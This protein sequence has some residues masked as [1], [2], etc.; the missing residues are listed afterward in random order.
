MEKSNIKEQ[1]LQSMIDELSIN[2]KEDGLGEKYSELLHNIKEKEHEMKKANKGFL[3]M[4]IL[5]FG[6][7][8]ASI[9]GNF[10]LL[11]RN[12]QV[13]LE[14]DNL[15]WRDS[16]FNAIMEPD[17]DKSVT[18]RI[19][20]GKI[21]TYHQLE[22][23]NDSFLKKYHEEKNKNQITQDSYV[24]R[25]KYEETIFQN[26]ILKGRINFI[27]SVY[28]IKIVEEKDGYR[29]VSPEIDSALL[30]LPHYRNML[31]RNSKDHSWTIKIVN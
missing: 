21:V 22:Q 27:T 24:S 17:S 26:E 29:L 14:L 15:K 9:V 28:H 23:Q 4:L 25:D 13:E 3:N 31:K 18:Y 2:I 1:S 12:D 30:L 8:I 6:T 20:N 16:L 11:D 5:V 7:F 19:N 10:L